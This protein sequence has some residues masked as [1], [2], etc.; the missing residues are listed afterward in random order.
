MYHRSDVSFI[1]KASDPDAVLNNLRNFKVE[2]SMVIKEAMIS[3]GE[4][5]P[6][7]TTTGNIHGLVTCKLND[8]ISTVLRLMVAN[9]SQRV[10]IVDEMQRIRGVISFRDILMYF[11][12]SSLR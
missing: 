3:A 8:S 9:R 7:V 12:E 5:S 10:V 1:M 2:D 11:I 6:P 4:I